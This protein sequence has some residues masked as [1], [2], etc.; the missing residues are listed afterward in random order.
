MVLGGNTNTLILQRNAAFG[1][2]T[3]AE[4]AQT[5][6]ANKWYR[7]EIVWGVGGSITGRLFDSDGTTLLNTVTAMDNTI[8]SGGLA[9]RGFGPTHYVDTVLKGGQANEDWYSITAVLGLLQFETSTPADGPGEFVNTL[10]PHIR[11]YDGTG[12][13]LLA[14]G[15]PLADGRNESINVSGLSVP[16]TYLVRV[17][18]EGGTRGEYFLRTVAPFSGFF[19]PLGKDQ[20]NAGSTI[21][22]KFSFGLNLGLDIL[23]PGSP[24]SRQINCSPDNCG[25]NVGIGPWEPTQSVPGL[26]FDPMDNQYIYNWKTLKAWAGTCRELDVILRDGRH[27]RISVRFK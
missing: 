7:F 25:A 17:T 14:T 20:Y 6:V 2:V 11:I 13:T 4:V 18:G 8:T 27:L 23:A 19:P 3:L 10:D 9:F 24:V 12:T 26:H 15:T 21:P 16:A 1:F 22:V 5:W